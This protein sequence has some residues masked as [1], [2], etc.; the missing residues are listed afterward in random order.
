LANRERPAGAI[1]WPLELTAAGII[2]Q[3]WRPDLS[4]GIWIAVF[5]A[6][7]TETNFLPV[8]YFAEMEMWFAS[9][10]V[11]T[12]VG[13]LIFGI[14]INA[15]AGDQGYLGFK[16]WQDPGPFAEYLLAG[17]MGKFLG[18]WSVL[19]QAS[20]SFQGTELVGMGTGE[21]RDPR[22]AVPRA[23]RNSCW[24]IVSM[25]SLTIFFIG[26]LVPYSNDALLK[27][28]TDAS[29]SPL[30]IAASLVGVRILPDV[31]NALL[32][33][34]VLSA[35]NSNVYSGSRIL[36][37]LANEGH[38]PKLLT[39][40]SRHGIPCYAIGLTSVFGLLAFLNLSPM[41]GNVFNWLVNIISV[42]GL[43]TWYCL[44]VCHLRFMGAMSAQ[45]IPRTALPYQGPWQPWLAWYGAA[46]N[47]LVI[48]TQGFTAFIPWNTTSFF[49]AY[50]S[51]FLFVGG[52]ATH[53][54]ICRT[55]MIPLLQ[56]DLQ[57]GRLES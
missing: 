11:V 55:K 50:I 17:T 3:Y 39:M 10:K 37:A 35:A 54:F 40:T 51:V 19:T 53:K 33:T 4:I 30:V 22:R 47:L 34:A 57:R 14:C 1:T 29:A 9:I 56:V 5:W 41:G 52:F 26:I 44:N 23:I 42:A 36:V 32:L 16:Y 21:A 20:F 31:V 8:R 2:I 7:F 6:V 24:S 15:G 13:F 49:V 25:F 12:I 28:S 45:N 27:D 48:I 46:F 43:L 38:A 18:F